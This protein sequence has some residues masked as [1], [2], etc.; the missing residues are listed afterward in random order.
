MLCHISHPRFPSRLDEAHERS[1]HTDILMG[2]LK[3]YVFGQRDDAQF[4]YGAVMNG[5]ECSCLLSARQDPT[6][7][8]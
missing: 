8:A 5:V 1:I 3:K 7:A 2:L 4:M 6:E